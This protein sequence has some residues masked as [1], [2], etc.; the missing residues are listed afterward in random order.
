[1]TPAEDEAQRLLDAAT[2]GNWEVWANCDNEKLAEVVAWDDDHHFG[3]VVMR[4]TSML[5]NAALI[6]AA[7]RL[8]AALLAELAQQRERIARIHQMLGCSINVE[9]TDEAQRED[10]EFFVDDGQGVVF[11]DSED[12][13]RIYAYTCMVSD[14]H[15]ALHAAPSSVVPVTEPRCP[16]CDSDDPEVVEDACDMPGRPPLDPW[17]GGQ[18]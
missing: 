1:V 10:G 17:H 4:T 16:T 7:P 11:F 5:N 14:R 13:A 8:L 12:E 6:A 3:I 18:Q 9:R 15:R 2:P